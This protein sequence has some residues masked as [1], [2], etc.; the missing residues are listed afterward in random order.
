MPLDIQYRR[1]LHLGRNGINV[2]FD[3]EKA[4]AF[5]F[6]WQDTL[7]LHQVG[8][9]WGSSRKTGQAQGYFYYHLQCIPQIMQTA[10]FGITT[11]SVLKWFTG[12]IHQYLWRL[13]YLYQ[14]NLWFI[15]LR[16]LLQSHL[17]IEQGPCFLCKRPRQN[18]KEMT[19]GPNW[20]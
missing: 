19:Q 17:I 20:E 10:C 15:Y 13:I 3:P 11:W 18:H 14:G 7:K 4:T 9:N 1:Y 12:R 8:L 16:G 5:V 2:L 6:L